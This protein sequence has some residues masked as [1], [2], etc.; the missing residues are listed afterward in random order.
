MRNAG[1]KNGG[2]TGRN[3]GRRKFLKTVALGAGALALPGGLGP[4]AQEAGAGPVGSGR[5]GKPKNGRRVNAQSG[6]APST[7]EYPRVFSG[8]HRQMV[9]FPLGGIGAGSISLGGRGQLCEWWIF[10]QPDKG[11]SPEY[12]FPSIWVKAGQGKP[13][14]RV[15]EAR[16][17]PPYEGPTGLGSANVPG[18]PRL[19]SSTLTGEFPLATVDFV[20]PGLPVR[21]KLEAFTPFIPLDADDSGLP[22][23]FL[24]YRVSNSGKAAALV[25]IAWSIQ[26]PVGEAGRTNDHRKS[27]RLEGLLMRN[28]FLSASDPL[29]GTLA[30]AL[31]DPGA[32]GTVTYLK[33]WPSRQ[34]WE[35]PLLFWD[36]FSSDGRLNSQSPVA[37]PVGS[38]CLQREIPAGAQREYT[39]LLA[40]RFPNRTAK[41]SGWTAPKGHENDVI[42]NHYCIRFSDAWQAAD[43]GAGRMSD[44]ESRT[45][46]FAA[47]IRKSTLP[48]AVKDAATANL[49][50]LV[51]PTSFRTAD[52]GF[53]G[54]EG[55]NEHSGCCFG[56]CTHVWN[57]EHALAHL[58]PALSRS[59]RERQFGYLTDPDGRMDFREL[60][61][62][63]IERWGLAAADGQMGVIIKLYLDWRL[64]GD[65]DWLKAQWPGAKRALEFA[66][67]AGG[68]DANRD[69][70]MEGVQ[71]NTY[72][73]EF[74]GPNPLCGI[75]Y[76]GA[77]R[78][79]EE[80]ARAL[81]DPVSADEYHRLFEQGSR[82][83]DANLFNGEYYI[84]KTGSISA[85]HVAPGLRVGMGAADLEHP[86]FQLGDGCLVDQLVGQYAANI[87]GLGPLLDRDHIR[88]CLKS[89][90]KY[91]YK[92]SLAEHETV[93]RT[94]AL[95]DE[96]GLVICDYSRGKRP[97]TPFPYFGELMTGFEY[98][99]GALMLDEGMIREGVEVIESIRRRYDGER[100]NPWDEAECGY[101]YARPMAS[102]SALL[103]L[104][105][106]R[107]D[108]VDESVT[109]KP[110]IH[111]EKFSCFW[112]APSGWGTF[113]QSINARGITFAIDVAEG[114]LPCRSVTLGRRATAGKSSARAGNRAVEHEVRSN[115]EESTFVFLSTARLT[116]AEGLQ[117][118]LEIST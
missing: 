103:A 22:L 56:S 76:L 104:S 97:E 34:W 32:D 50:A 14:A 108:G 47:S 69:G 96:A 39:F 101:Y 35:G 4:Q 107:Y 72:D 18:L 36:D 13:I 15:L 3:R 59:L 113:S 17:M 41:R 21:V 25:S 10:N 87:A 12:A 19:A 62:G 92:R 52:G 98:S 118:H 74:V 49:S 116:K 110:R 53:H 48:G 111:A 115:G 85:D 31:V 83:I 28:P 58:F 55:C 86:T 11:N 33:G 73:V 64:S 106:F 54:F 79:G 45:R 75:W 68:W 26:N 112:S 66:W 102:W 44:L 91:N 38:L 27:E 109:A 43:Y 1:G 57:Y 99:T 5:N 105:G 23:A 80:M 8:S 88:T 81:G 89:I 78:A 51:T 20:D 71:H 29:A 82:W 93:Q 67:I 42:G 70:V 100:R 40:W 60:L 94:F 37:T 24:R 46:A 117:L 9:A 114:E 95:N 16:F 63:G 2:K 7:I 6:P 61:P 30:L 84:Q 65:L 90:Y 77:L